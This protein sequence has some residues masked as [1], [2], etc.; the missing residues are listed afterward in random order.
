MVRSAF[1][2]SVQIGGCSSY[3]LC[4][5]GFPPRRVCV[6]ERRVLPYLTLP[7]TRR[8]KAGRESNGE[9]AYP[10]VTFLSPSTSLKSSTGVTVPAGPFVPF[11]F[12][13]KGLSNRGGH[14]IAACLPKCQFAIGACVT[15]VG[16]RA[17]FV[18]PIEREV[19]T[20]RKS[21]ESTH[22]NAHRPATTTRNTDWR[23]GR[24]ARC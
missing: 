9:S 15:L 16:D 11:Q 4:M 3:T 21:D 2:A 18:A 24:V 23:C 6:A 20:L 8:V 19:I 5:P 17:G 14:V 12:K 7:P 10:T 22:A 13:G 1:R